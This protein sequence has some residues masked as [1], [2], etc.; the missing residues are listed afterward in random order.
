MISEP[1]IYSNSPVHRLDP[2]VRIIVAVVYSFVIALSV[3]FVT[4]YAALALSF[5]LIFLAKLDIVE[6][7][8]RLAIANGFVFFFWL[9]VPLTFQGEPLFYL[10][11][12]PVVRSGVMLS[13]QITL[14]TNAILALLIATTAT[15]P[16]STIGNALNLLHIPEKMVHLLLLTYR[17]I[18]VM[19]Q[20]YMRLIRAAK[21]RGF[22]P[23]TNMHTY[24]TYAYLLGM[25]FVRAFSRAH[26]VH[27]AM[28]CRGFNG[29]FHCLYTFS[30]SR[31][32]WI[33]SATMAITIAGFIIMEW[34]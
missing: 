22:S 25:L 27:Q 11:K 34:I 31:R 17:Y 14:K 4:L 26:R 3:K 10:W 32:D 21:I 28:Q 19:E 5:F 33:F 20:E 23:K 30:M 9:A 1:F 24:K 2:R 15:M 16:T 12:L 18:F 6:V 29:R 8:R 7:A 13:A